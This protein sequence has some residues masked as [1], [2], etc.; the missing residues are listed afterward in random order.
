MS[1]EVLSGLLE[2]FRP[3]GLALCQRMVE[4][5]RKLGFADERPL[6]AFEAAA[7]SLVKD[8]Y[9]G[10]EGLVATWTNRHGH[11]I[12]GI[13]FNGDGSYFAEFDVAEPHP[14]DRRWFV[15][16][17]SAW[18]RDGTVKAEPKLLAALE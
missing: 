10:K 12:G 18:G 9:S 14:S 7:Y 16:G 8:S 6:P 4:E 5:I 11:R 15:E 1:D 13:L 3:S 2:R 17:V